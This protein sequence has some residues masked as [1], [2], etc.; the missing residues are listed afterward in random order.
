MIA[1][2][3]ILFIG[4]MTINKWILP[5]LFIAGLV[6]LV[7]PDQGKPVILIN[8]SH[9]PSFLDLIGLLLMMIPW[10]VSCIVVIRKWKEVRLKTGNSNFRLLVT[11]YFISIIGV[12]LS[13]LF[14]SDL[15]LWLC[16]IVATFINVLFI[17]Y[18]SNK[19]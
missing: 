7:L 18:A 14:S 8:E 5:V 17:L 10:F 15:T 2:Y 11:G 1:C 13:L 12:A 4:V 9:G 6:I 16:V 3:C 19:G